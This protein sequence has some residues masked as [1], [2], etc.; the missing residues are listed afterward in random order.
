[1]NHPLLSALAWSLPWIVPPLITYVRLR[2]SCSLDD[3]SD[4]PPE[5][6]PLVSVIVPARNEA[7]NIA[8]CVS[9]ILS[10]SYPRIELLVVDDASTD[11]TSGI[12][13]ESAGGDTRMRIITS[14]ELPEGW[15]GKQWACA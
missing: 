11:G 1:M 7:H 10:T 3:E 8:R 5:N 15:F 13:R 12:A 9:S 2:H 6:P 4:T 14:S